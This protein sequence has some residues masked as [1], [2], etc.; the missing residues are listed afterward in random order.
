MPT[1][2]ECQNIRNNIGQN[3]KFKKIKN[4]ITDSATKQK[5]E[6]KKIEHKL[7]SDNKINGQGNKNTNNNQVSLNCNCISKYSY[8]IIFGILYPS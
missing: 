6:N 1:E 5:L 2:T 7:T 4:I 3:K 8:N